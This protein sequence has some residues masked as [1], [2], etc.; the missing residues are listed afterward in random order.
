M[1]DPGRHWQCSRRPQPAA[2]LSDVSARLGTSA[3]ALF[4]FDKVFLPCVR[5]AYQYFRPQFITCISAATF[6]G[7]ELWS[8]VRSKSLGGLDAFF[9][10]YERC[11]T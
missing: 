4:V 10:V 1:A 7:A 8:D 9:V 2:A 3:S 11:C 6:S 5:A